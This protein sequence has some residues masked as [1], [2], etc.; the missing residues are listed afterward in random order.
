MYEP[1]LTGKFITQA[2]NIAVQP[3]VQSDQSAALRCA[4]LRFL[5]LH[6]TKRGG[7]NRAV[8]SLFREP[9]KELSHMGDDSR[10]RLL[11]SARF[12]SWRRIQ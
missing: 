9:M 10:R 7:A 4:F 3:R 1:I 8:G 2:E 11:V 5:V 12:V 6:P